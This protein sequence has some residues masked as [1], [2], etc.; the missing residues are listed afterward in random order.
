MATTQTNIFSYSIGRKF[1]M[2]LTGMFLI[3]FLI[4]HCAVNACIFY[5]DGGKTFNMVAE[6]FG[7]NIFIRTIEIF[8]FLGLI[9]H[10]VQSYQLTVQNKKARPVQYAVFDG[11]KNSKWYSRS[12]GLLGTLILIFLI[13][14]LKHFWVETR[15]T[16][17]EKPTLYDEMREVF[18]NLWVVILYV[19]AQVSLAYHLLHGFKSSFQ[20]MGW[21]H[22]KYNGIISQTGFWFSIIICL[23]FAIMPVAMYAGWVK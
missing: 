7:T 8:L 11:N 17:L 4:V 9:I 16:G 23:L 18:S 2:G 13:I 12:M 21:N 19:A 1:V 10:I 22:P 6:F 14:H 3:T 15:F 20:S 5:N